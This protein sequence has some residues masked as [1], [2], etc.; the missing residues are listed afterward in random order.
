M[1]WSRVNATYFMERTPGK[2]DRL[3]LGEGESEFNVDGIG[4]RRVFCERLRV[5]KPCKDFYGLL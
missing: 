5:N 1:P 4:L 3:F 2:D